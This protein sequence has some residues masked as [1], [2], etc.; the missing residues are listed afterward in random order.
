[1]AQNDTIKYTTVNTDSGYGSLQNLYNTP[2][3]KVSYS[4]K[5]VGVAFVLIVS[6]IAS[7]MYSATSEAE[8]NNNNQ[9]GS[10]YS[11]SINVGKENIRVH[12]SSTSAWS[13]RQE[14]YN[15]LF[16]SFYRNFN[17]GQQDINVFMPLFNMLTSQLKQLDIK[18]AFVD[19]GRKKGMIDFNLYLENEVFLSVA[20]QL[21]DSDDEVMFTIARNHQTL[22]IDMMPIG[23]LMQKMAE[24]MMELKSL[25]K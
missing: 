9:I 8:I 7:S 13:H 23:E 3:S 15:L 21:S 12:F 16:E 6:P 20:K 1:M 4:L 25:P 22:V 18:D 14:M 11:R 10:L 2:Q 17:R 19:V 5:A 24:I